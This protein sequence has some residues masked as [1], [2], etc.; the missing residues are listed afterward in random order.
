MI[1]Q[2]ENSPSTIP[3]SIFTGPEVVL[4]ASHLQ[5]CLLGRQDT[6]RHCHSQKTSRRNQKS[7]STLETPHAHTFPIRSTS[8]VTLTLSCSPV[9]PKTVHK[10]SMHAR[11][12]RCYGCEKKVNLK[13]R[14]VHRAGELREKRGS[15][16]VHWLRARDHRV[17]VLHVY[18][19]SEVICY[20][21]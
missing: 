8:C 2:P 4:V 10:A 12:Q 13:R 5:Q 20:D 3:R 15:S 11:M 14:W 16:L 18:V 1:V 19:G 9:R 17:C 21:R 6:P 7:S